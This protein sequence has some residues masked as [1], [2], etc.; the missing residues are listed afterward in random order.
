MNLAN[1]KRPASD[2]LHGTRA[3]AGYL[4]CSEQTV[5]NKCERGELRAIRTS[6]GRWLVSQSEI[7]RFKRGAWQ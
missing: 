5:R 7:D 6:S 2:E 1:D 3:A 4:D